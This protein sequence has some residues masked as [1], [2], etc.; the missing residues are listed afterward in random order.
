MK[1]MEVLEL[2]KMVLLLVL[3]SKNLSYSVKS[4]EFHCLLSK[5]SPQLLK[6][7][8]VQGTVYR[9]DSTATF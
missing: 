8:I 3:P 7:L 9:I 1:P 4:Q 2:L 6:Q 5:E